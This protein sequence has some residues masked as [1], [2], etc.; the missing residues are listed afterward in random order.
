MVLRI[1]CLPAI[2][3]YNAAGPP[4]PA[5]KPMLLLAAVAARESVS[6]KLY[7]SEQGIAVLN[8]YI[9]ILGNLQARG[10]PTPPVRLEKPHRDIHVPDRRLKALLPHALLS[11][12]TQGLVRAGACVCKNFN[13]LQ[14]I[15]NPRMDAQA[16]IAIDTVNRLVVVSYRPTVSQQNWRTGTDMKLVRYPTL[17]RDIR[18]H[19]GYLRHLIAT[20]AATEAAVLRLLTEPK[21]KKHTLHITGFNIGGSLAAIATPM[22]HALL[23][24]HRLKNRIKVFVYSNPRPG[25][26]AFANHLNSLNITVIRYSKGGDVVPHLPPQEAGYAQVGKEFFQ[27]ASL[28]ITS[29]SSAF[30]QDPHC[31]LKHDKFNARSHF[32]PFSADMPT[33][34]FC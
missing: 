30:A 21:Y 4:W 5:M 6:S 18:V 11:V 26:V 9:A 10:I 23:R 16:A 19:K 24:T 17:G 34:P 27:D 32:L 29:C 7:N 28:P 14:L 13:R 12:C 2:A 20:H 25:N 15:T 3:P 8:S 22:W 33:P 1:D 31:G